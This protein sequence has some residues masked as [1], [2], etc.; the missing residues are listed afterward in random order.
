MTRLE[1]IR[2]TLTAADVVRI[3][4]GNMLCDVC[5]AAEDCAAVKVEDEDGVEDECER[6]IFA[7]LN[8][9]VTDTPCTIRD[10]IRD[11][12][13]ERGIKLAWLA[14]QAGIHRSALYMFLAGS[15]TIPFAA[16]EKIFRLLE[17]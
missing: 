9:T 8:R 3:V 16:L 13:N 7:A 14:E 5:P 17:L 2:Q 12:A 4:S 6:L 11:R 1:K 15:R 10:R